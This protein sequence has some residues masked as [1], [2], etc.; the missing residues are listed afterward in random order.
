MSKT[1]SNPWMY[2]KQFSSNECI[3]FKWKENSYSVF[4]NISEIPYFLKSISILNFK[5]GVCDFSISF[6][7]GKPHLM[8]EKATNNLL[9]FSN[10]I[11]KLPSMYQ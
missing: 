9:L 3:L 6:E 10:V 5:M 8:V 1:K 11:Q 4:Y 7:S 2:C